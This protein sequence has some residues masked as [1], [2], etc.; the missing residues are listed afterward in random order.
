[1]IEIPNLSGILPRFTSLEYRD[2]TVHLTFSIHGQAALL[3]LLGVGEGTYV[4]GLG[5][6]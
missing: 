5:V 2:S 1:M 6:N 3:F 4:Q